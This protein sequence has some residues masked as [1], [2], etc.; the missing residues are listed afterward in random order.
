MVELKPRNLAKN[1]WRQKHMLQM[2][3][4]SIQG[5]RS[6]HT[7]KYAWQFVAEGESIMF[8]D[9]AEDLGWTT[10]LYGYVLC[11]KLLVM[12]TSLI[13][14]SR[15]VMVLR[16]TLSGT[17]ANISLPV[18][19]G[20]QYMPR[21][22]GRGILRDIL[23]AIYQGSICHTIEALTIYSICR[24]SRL[25]FPWQCCVT[26]LPTYSSWSWLK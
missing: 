8:I 20:V 6:V 1:L 22:I 18:Q 3:W 26:A 4:R 5:F 10:T 24:L 2:A 14:P 12:I 25:R 9:L 11:F 23:W 15:S 21:P 7:D 13:F 17:N 19:F 16:S